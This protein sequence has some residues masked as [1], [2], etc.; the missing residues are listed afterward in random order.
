[1]TTAA[2]AL[3][4][5]N[6]RLAEMTEVRA[7]YGKSVTPREQIEFTAAA[8]AL[9]MVEADDDAIDAADLLLVSSATIQE[10]FVAGIITASGVRAPTSSVAFA[11]R[12]RILDVISAMS[13]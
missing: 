4:A 10:H 1:M 11:A 6:A 8:T 5:L 7:E 2:A 3:A 9:G 13:R 12:K